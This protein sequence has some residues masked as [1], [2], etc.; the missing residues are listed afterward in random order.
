MTC[1]NLELHLHW[2]KENDADNSFGF[3]KLENMQ[4]TYKQ[5]TSFS[6]NAEVLEEFGEEDLLDADNVLLVVGV[7]FVLCFGSIFWY[8]SACLY[9]CCW[10]MQET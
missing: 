1:C 5:I 10:E 4:R 3:S 7:V 9:T 2:N 8:C 6:F